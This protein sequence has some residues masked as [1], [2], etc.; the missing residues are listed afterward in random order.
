MTDPEA[1][2]LLP[3][4]LAC[5]LMLP[6]IAGAQERR[7]P[8]AELFSRLPER[9][10]NSEF[11]W[12]DLR[13]QTGVQW[14]DFIEQDFSQEGDMPPGLAGSTD[15]TLSVRHVGRRLE[16][17]GHARYTYKEFRQ[18]R[19]FGAPGYDGSGLVTFKASNRLRFDAGGLVARSPFFH[20]MNPA[21]LDF[22]EPTLAGDPFVALLVDNDTLEGHGGLPAQYSKRSSVV[23]SGRWRE[24]RFKNRTDD[25]FAM[26]GFRGEWRRRMTR[27]LGVHAG[28]A[29]DEHRQRRLGDSRF[30]NELFDIGIDYSKALPIAR[31][32]TLALLTETSAVRENGGKRQFRVNGTLELQHG[33]MRTWRVSAGAF[34]ATEFIP[35]IAEPVFSDRLRAGVSGFLSRRLI[36]RANADGTQAQIG[37]NDPGKF[38]M[39]AADARLTFAI[40]RRVGLFGQYAYY[41]YQL[42][43]RVDAIAQLPKLSRQTYVVGLETWFRLL[44]RDDRHNRKPEEPETETRRDPR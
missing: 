33:F 10:A 18:E 32:T 16:G 31:R 39:Y 6:A 25:N 9:E 38:Q 23:V 22:G 17:Q 35:G 21:P 40:T 1:K 30:M 27:D 12:L 4:A 3:F 11:T 26:R 29:R 41:H 13:T 2:R 7:N 42:P 19:A 34:R 44:D 15:A 5:V 20:L 24:T 36:F 28:Y 14:A 8:F 37:F 43:P